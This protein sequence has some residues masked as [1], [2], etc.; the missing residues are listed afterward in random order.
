MQL[1]RLLLL[2]L[3]L[4]SL[5]PR[6]ARADE[7][8]G[9]WSGEVAARGD[10]YWERSTRVTAPSLDIRLASPDGTRFSGHYLVD[11]ITSASQAAGALVDVRFTETRHEAFVGI[12]REFRVGELPLDLDGRIR[13]SRE[14]DYLS[15]SAGVNGALYLSRRA[16]VLRFSL[17]ALHDEVRQNF[18]GGTGSRPNPDGSISA[19]SFADDLD[20]VNT[21]VGYEQILSRRSY[22]TVQYEFSAAR[23]FLAN[24]Y[25]LVSVAGILRGETHPRVRNRHTITGRYAIAWPRI[26]A[27]TH[28]TLR[29]Y[30]D[31]WDIRAI[32]PEVRWYQEADRAL[33]LRFRYRYYQQSAAFFQEDDAAQYRA[34]SAFFT[35]DPKM[36]AFRSHELGLAA[37]LGLEMLEGTSLDMLSHV[38]IDFAFDYRWNE[39]AF[40]DGVVATLGLRVPFE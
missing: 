1:N 13:M 26:H 22:A 37:T 12:G 21:S 5:A 20:V 28:L 2:A 36:D 15:L 31:D 7:I 38:K 32:T 29:G 34:D 17:L 14:P 19:N 33:L 25:R 6:L 39:N 27:S 11:A 23:G 3:A 16:R 4:A 24:A 10:Y 40:G 8:T 9:T 18:R 30:S 35:A